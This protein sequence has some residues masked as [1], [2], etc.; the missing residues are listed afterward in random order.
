M[1]LWLCHTKQPL[2]HVIQLVMLPL[3]V[4]PVTDDVFS[5]YFITSSTLL[6]QIDFDVFLNVNC[7]N[8]AALPCLRS[9]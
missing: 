5:V 4:L 9:C 2:A 7:Y 8:I 1:N 6:R 3:I